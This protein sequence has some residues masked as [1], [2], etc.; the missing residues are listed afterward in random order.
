MAAKDEVDLLRRQGLYKCCVCSCRCA[1]VNEGVRTKQQP[2][3]HD[4][5]ECHIYKSNSYSCCRSAPRLYSHSFSLSLSLLTAQTYGV[6]R[7]L[8]LQHPLLWKH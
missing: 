8:Y 4:Y 2:E 6:A 3:K 5:S 1:D 7:I